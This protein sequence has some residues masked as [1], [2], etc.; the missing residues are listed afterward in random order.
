MSRRKGE[1]T[2]KH[3]NRSH[4][5]QVEIVVPGTGLR[6]AA[7]IM[8]R[9]A[10]Q[11]DHAVTHPR[12]PG[13]PEVRLMRWCFCTRQA[14]DTFATDFGGQRVDL[15]VDTLSLKVDKPDEAELKR[16]AKAQ[17]FGLYDDAGS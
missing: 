15:P 14:A 5:F 9:W 7:N 3:K 11:H 16:R 8:Y 4:P 2:D 13:R 10:A 17:S 6:N 12:E 1:V